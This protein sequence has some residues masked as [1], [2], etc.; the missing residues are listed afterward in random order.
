[1]HRKY[2][3]ELYKLAISKGADSF[4][5]KSIVS[6]TYRKVVDKVF[7]F[8]FK[9]ENSFR[10]W[11]F[12]IVSNCVIDIYRINSKTGLEF[13][14]YDENNFENKDFDSLTIT[15]S[16]ILKNIKNDYYSSGI[17]FD[18]R[19]EIVN[20]C[21]SKLNDEERNLFLCYLEGIKIS[22]MIGYFNTNENNLKQKLR[23]VRL[24]FINELA[25]ITPINNEALNEKIK[26]I[27]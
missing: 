5:A 23:R 17:G 18:D 6:D 19:I 27:H 11:L 3:D 8:Q 9:N 14:F 21:L 15:E 7:D 2:S 22:E 26:D 24:K 20:Y 4:D 10:N 13:E 25:K 16:K 12:K 1:M